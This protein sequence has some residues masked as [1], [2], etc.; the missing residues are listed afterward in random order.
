VAAREDWRTVP[1][2]PA[3]V[4]VALALQWNAL[5]RPRRAGVAARSMPGLL[6]GGA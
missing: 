5:L 1:L 3:I 4:A 2:H 6:G